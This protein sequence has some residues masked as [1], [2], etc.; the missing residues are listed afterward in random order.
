LL[1]NLFAFKPTDLASILYPENT[2]TKTAL[3]PQPQ[4]L[5]FDGATQQKLT[6][7]YF[8]LDALSDYFPLFLDTAYESQLALSPYIVHINKSTRPFIEWLYH[9]S[10]Q[11]CFLYTSP[12]TLQEQA[13]YWQSLLIALN[14]DGEEV[15]FRFY[16]AHVLFHYLMGCS[17][18]EVQQLLKPCTSL[19]IQD[20]KCQ[21]LHTPL[22]ASPNQTLQPQN[23]APWWQIKNKHLDNLKNSKTDVL[24]KH[25]EL[26]LWRH[27]P[28]ALSR[29]PFKKIPKIIV[30]GLQKADKWKLTENDSIT[31]F[32]SCLFL[33][34]DDFDSQPHAIHH[35]QQKGSTANQ[36]ALTLQQ[37][38]KR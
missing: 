32:I 23:T 8:S 26:Q 14:E 17:A 7:H 21:W 2:E 9:Q 16:D 25:I 10:E 6:E 36:Q 28:Q 11:W 24:A 22:N 3:K 31:C 34:G 13:I 29:H 37:H 15:L 12:Y 18:T 20:D 4:Y 33:F 5:I 1:P 35:L 19:T 38:I 30:Q 27:H